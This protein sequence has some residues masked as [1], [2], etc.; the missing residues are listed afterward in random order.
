[1]RFPSRSIAQAPRDANANQSGCL[2][3]P[4]EHSVFTSWK[5]IV[6]FDPE[7]IVVMP[8]GFDLQRTLT[9]ARTLRSFPNWNAIS[10]VRTGR[11]Y[12]TDGNA[13][14]NRS[15]PRL[16]N[17]LEILSGLLHPEFF[18]PPDPRVATR[19]PDGQGLFFS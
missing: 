4:G 5:D 12:A 2:A 14:F 15:G 3:R 13:Y 11:V 1:M 9:E 10:A 16:V 19:L 8:C 17:S 18:E 6:A 7:V